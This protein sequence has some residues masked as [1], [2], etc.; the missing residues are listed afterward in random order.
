VKRC[1]GSWRKRAQSKAE[2]G[3][4]PVA[5]SGCDQ[6]HRGVVLFGP[7]NEDLRADGVQRGQHVAKCV[8]LR[9][10]EYQVR[11]M[12]VSLPVRGVNSL[13]LTRGWLVQVDSG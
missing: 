10:F 6:G 1:A 7:A 4:W 5:V 12:E 3:R 13:V 2:R 11:V 9:K 8:M